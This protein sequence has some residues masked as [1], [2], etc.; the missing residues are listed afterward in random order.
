MRRALHAEWTKLRTV[1]SP[2]WLL[3]GMIATTVVMSAGAASLM[4]C[5]SAGCGGDLT[6]IN[7]LG[8]ELGQ[9]LVVILA[10]LVIGGEYSTGMI[11][12]SLVAVPRRLTVFAAKA[13]I[14]TVVV[15]TAGSLAVLGSLLAGR[16]ILPNHAEPTEGRAIAGSVLYLILIALLSLG[17]SVIVRDSA[18]SIGAILGLLYLP[19]ILGQTVADPRWQELLQQVAPTSATL[20]VTAG[21]SAA[22]LTTG[23]LLLRTRD[24]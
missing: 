19:P 10:V 8:V 22:A 15:A 24:G 9:A 12:T 20:G 23:G 4:A 3:L 2:L 1:A 14:L 13:G 5:E 17:I 21:W 11:R 6:Q 18:T 7:R 16:L